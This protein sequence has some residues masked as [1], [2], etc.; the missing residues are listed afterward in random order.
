MRQ[1]GLDR[2]R[3]FDTGDNLELTSA[4]PAGGN[5]DIEHPLEPLRPAH[6]HMGIRGF[7][8]RGGLGLIAL[9]SL[10][11]CHLRPM[12]AVGGEYA[13]VPGE[14]APH[15]PAGRRFPPC[16]GRHNSRRLQEKATSF[17]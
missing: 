8:S 15:P 2:H 13:M 5:I 6:S 4:V 3:V 1:Y 14:A 11:W 12:P 10:G 17:S 16:G 9:A 7:L